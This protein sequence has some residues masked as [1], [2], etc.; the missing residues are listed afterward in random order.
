MFEKRAHMF[1]H[2]KAKHDPA[3]YQQGTWRPSV[4]KKKALCI[5]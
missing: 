2:Y 5:N 1:R 4:D 3:V